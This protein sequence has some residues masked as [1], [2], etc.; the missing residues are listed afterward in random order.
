MP[1]RLLVLSDQTLAGLLACEERG[2]RSAFL[3]RMRYAV[4]GRARRVPSTEY[5]L[6]DSQCSAARS[7]RTDLRWSRSAYQ[8]PVPVPATPSHA[9]QIQ[10]HS[11]FHIPRSTPASCAGRC[12]LACSVSAPGCAHGRAVAFGDSAGMVHTY[13][14]TSPAAPRTADA[15]GGSM[16]GWPVARKKRGLDLERSKGQR[17]EDWD[18]HQVMV[19]NMERRH[20]LM[21][22]DVID[23]H[24]HAYTYTEGG[25]PNVERGGGRRPRLFNLISAARQ[26]DRVCNVG[27]NG[28]HVAAVVIDPVPISSSLSASAG[29][30]SRRPSLSQGREH[31]PS[32]A[33][34]SIAAAGQRSGYGTQG[35]VM[36]M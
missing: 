23:A 7:R 1:A 22:C 32:G 29:S 27:V 3:E 18:H 14:A 12:M 17:R 24:L 19:S 10:T 15:H 36:A 34:F 2:W 21:H 9:T 13:T 8:V 31:T 16:R 25:I 30:S 26:H 11:T 28:M 33:A 20:T 6:T 4:C 35:L 5:R